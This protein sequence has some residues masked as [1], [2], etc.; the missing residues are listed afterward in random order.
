MEPK[1]PLIDSSQI[2]EGADM[3]KRELA[4]ILVSIEQL[5]PGIK[6]K[7]ITELA[8]EE[9]RNSDT[10]ATDVYAENLMEDVFTAFADELGG[11]KEN[12][13]L[14]NG[15]QGQIVIDLGAGNIHGYLAS[16][17]GKAKGYVAVDK[18]QDLSDLYRDPKKVSETIKE[19]YLLQAQGKLAIPA[20]VEKEDMLTFLRRLPSNSVSIISSGHFGLFQNDRYIDEVQKEMDRVL[21][22]DGFLIWNDG[23]P[24]DINREEEIPQAC[25]GGRIRVFVKKDSEKYRDSVRE[26]EAFTRQVDAENDIGKLQEMQK[27]AEQAGMDRKHFGFIAE[28]W[29]R[30]QYE[31]H[32]R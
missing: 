29:L 25:A 30:L 14:A 4:P 18:Y 8:W 13:L 20:A 16:I 7:A 9:S 32:S 28:K 21:S 15:L 12:S 3:E 27:Q 10:Y 11:P 5:I 2:E 22:P 24:P 6:P 17:A 23:I 19:T 1:E 26:W 31:Q